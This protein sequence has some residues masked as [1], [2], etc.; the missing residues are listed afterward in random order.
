MPNIITVPPRV[1][2]TNE[3]QLP[4][5]GGTIE[6]NYTY[7]TTVDGSSITPTVTIGS[8]WISNLSI[9]RTARKITAVASTNTGKLERNG[10]I[11][12]SFSDVSGKTY[13]NYCA[14]KQSTTNSSIINGTIIPQTSTIIA[15]QEGSSGTLTFSTQG[16][17]V[18]TIE[19]TSDSSWFKVDKVTTTTVY[20]TVEA[21][22]GNSRTCKLTISAKNSNNDN[23]AS[24]VV[25]VQQAKGG[26][27]PYLEFEQSNFNVG[28]GS[29][30]TNT[31]INYFDFDYIG[32]NNTIEYSCDA[33]W[34]TFGSGSG[35]VIDD[36]GNFKERGFV[37]FGHNENGDTSPSRTA[38]VTLRGWNSASSA[39]AEASFTIRQD[40]GA[41]YRPSVGV[42]E[43]PSS[44]MLG[45]WKGTSGSFNFSTKGMMVQR[46]ISAATNTAIVTSLSLNNTTKK[47]SY[48]IV[49]NTVNDIRA[50]AITLYGY[51]TIG[52]YVSSDVMLVQDASPQIVEFPIWRDTDIL[53]ESD[54]VYV[55]YIIRDEFSEQV[56]YS[57]RAYMRDGK[58]SVRINDILRQHIRETLTFDEE[59]LQDNGAYIQALMMLSDDGENYA[60]YRRIKCYNDWTY[61]RTN[62]SFI[63][64]PIRYEFDP[65]QYL[66]C[67]AI[68]YADEFPTIMLTTTVGGGTR[69]QTYSLTNQIGTLLKRVNFADEVQVT[70]GNETMAYKQVKEPCHRYL[71]YYKND[72][73][74][75]DSFL[76]KG[77]CTRTDSMDTYTYKRN[78]SNQTNE[79]DTLQY[80]RVAKPTWNLTSD[81]MTDNETVLFA[82][83]VHSNRVWLHDLVEDKVVPV[84]VST[85]S[86][87]YKT[88]RSN[89]RRFFTNSITVELAQDRFIR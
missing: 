43:A 20:Y 58:C 53:I 73:G 39:I 59:G 71:V 1:D 60:E 68:D 3:V 82:N 29:A 8:S 44:I 37:R 27:K 36:D 77:K 16:V 51:D 13:S 30:D 81:Y 41:H 49:D 65:R 88:F 78:V 80:M 87:E 21:N 2:L 19:A 6:I 64:M 4:K 11:S 45:T 10:T 85:S 79:H 54:N 47:V 23:F 86:Y 24:T 72:K 12:V 25:T 7:T 70:I 38:T 55:D 28:V 40:Q 89:G 17:D 67:S 46:G 14:I 34:V 69:T 84:N 48:S 31:Y 18:L 9:D 35:E 42:I 26:E 57:G 50:V 32:G 52:N 56:I 66:V 76:F 75:F 5:S 61:E 62:N 63:S 33:D 22:V 83:L 74:G 15:K